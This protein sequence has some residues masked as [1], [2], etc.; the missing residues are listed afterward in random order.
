MNKENTAGRMDRRTTLKLIGAAVPFVALAAG[1]AEAS[2]MSQKLSHYRD[3]PKNG[4]DCQGCKFFVHPHSC[5]V[6]DGYIS[7]KG[8]CMLWQKK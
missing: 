6:V 8:W 4:K 3:D 2:K 1:P 5:T 7:P